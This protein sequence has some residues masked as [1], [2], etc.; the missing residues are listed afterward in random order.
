MSKYR[1]PIV[2]ENHIDKLHELVGEIVVPQGTIFTPKAK[3]KIREK[4]LHVTY[5]M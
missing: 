5:D 2:T 3:E 1:T 4:K